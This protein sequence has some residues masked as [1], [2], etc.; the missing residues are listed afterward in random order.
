MTSTSSPSSTDTWLS[1]Q[2]PFDRLPPKAVAQLSQKVKWVRY[3]MGQPMVPRDRLPGQIYVLSKG[4]ARTIGHDP[5]TKLPASM[6]S[7]GTGQLVGW[8]GLVR[9]RP[10]EAVISSTESTAAVIPSTAFLEL[11]DRY[12]E[13]LEWT[14]TPQL[15]EV[16]DLLGIYL[17]GRADGKVVYERQ[18][19]SDLRE[20][21]LKLVPQ[22]TLQVVERATDAEALDEDTLWLVSNGAAVGS[23]IESVGDA[24]R[25]LAEVEAP[26]RLI[27]IPVTALLSSSSVAHALSVASSSKASKSAALANSGSSALALNSAEIP[28]AEGALETLPATRKQRRQA[29]SE[30]FPFV[31]GRGPIDAPMACFQML[32]QYF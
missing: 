16:F 31:R 4:Q 8:L 23:E 32:S 19:V 27:G 9:D 18:G 15:L 30:R 20:L 22:T 1:Q 28:F 11:L 12:P 7:L 13:L 17:K 25:L 24:Q 29:S 10:C 3:R 2:P 26:L 6:G 14:Q 21:A 5:D